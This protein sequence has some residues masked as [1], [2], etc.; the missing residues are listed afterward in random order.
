MEADLGVVLGHHPD[1][2]LHDTGLE[3]GPSKI[4]RKNSIISIVLLFSPLVSEF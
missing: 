2:V 4:V 3:V 1:I